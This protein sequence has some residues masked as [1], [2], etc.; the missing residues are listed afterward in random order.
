MKKYIG[1]LFI[2]LLSI[3]QLQAQ[4]TI[5][6]PDTLSGWSYGWVAGL[7][8]AQASYSNWSQ[9]GVN[10][11]AVSGNSTFRTYYRDG[12]FSYGFLLNTR[13]G[14]TRIDGEGTRKT[15]DRLSIR[16]RFL[17]DLGTDSSDFSVYGNLNFRTQFDRG[18]DYGAGPGGGDLVISN[19]FSPA[20]I[21]QNVG[22]LYSPGEYFSFE[23]GAGLRQTIVSGEDVLD[24]NNYGLPAG[25][26]FRNEAG[27][28]L[29]ASYQQNIAS[30]L[31]MSVN[32]ETFTN[33]NKSLSSTDVFFSSEFIGQIN[34]LI[35]TSLR[36]DVVYDDDFSKEIQLRQSLTVGISFILI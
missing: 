22:M 18:F 10:N 4:E 8:G 27:V 35:N 7:N 1:I 13:Y 11:M 21:S 25:D 2:L 34:S 31:L 32:A 30:N 29:G 20:Y 36:F 16:N 23:A 26:N 6:V 17:Y 3:T 12:K 9:G 28:N 14:K 15:D 19:F 24:N 33:V 5:V